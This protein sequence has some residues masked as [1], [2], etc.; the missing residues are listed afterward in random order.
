[1]QRIYD[2]FRFVCKVWLPCS[3]LILLMPFMHKIAYAN[4]T[5]ENDS[6]STDATEND[7][8]TNDNN[9]HY[10]D[11]SVYDRDIYLPISFSSSSQVTNTVTVY[12]RPEDTM[13]INPG[14][15]GPSFMFNPGDDN[16]IDGKVIIEM[17][18]VII[19]DPNDRYD[20]NDSASNNY[21]SIMTS[22]M[23]SQDSLLF[24]VNDNAVF[25]VE[26]N[27]RSGTVVDMDDIINY[28]S[29][30]INFDIRDGGHLILKP[31]PSAAKDGVTE[32]DYSGVNFDGSHITMDVQDE[33][34]VYVRGNMGNSTIVDKVE[35][36]GG[37]VHFLGNMR[38]N[39]LLSPSSTV[40]FDSAA[41][42]P[43][44]EG[45][46]MP[47]E[48]KDG[49]VQ[50]TKGGNF[51]MSFGSKDK[52]L[53]SF[54]TTVSTA[55]ST[56][57]IITIHGD[58]YAETVEL[59]GGD[60]VVRFLGDVNPSE[61]ILIDDEVQEV[62]FQGDSE[63]EHDIYLALDTSDLTGIVPDT[64]H[65]NIY[66]MDD[67]V[68]TAD[69]IGNNSAG[70]NDIYVQDN[71]ELSGVNV[72]SNNF[73]VTGGNITFGDNGTQDGV[74]VNVKE[75]FSN[76]ADI[77]LHGKLF[78][79]SSSFDMA[80]NN[81]I[82]LNVTRVYDGNESAISIDGGSSYSSSNRVLVMAPVYLVDGSTNLLRDTITGS[83]LDNLDI[84]DSKLA[85]YS[86]EVNDN[87][88]MVTIVA[89]PKE[90]E[91]ILDDTGIT[92]DDL[93]ILRQALQAVSADEDSTVISALNRLFSDESNDGMRRVSRQLSLDSDMSHSSMSISPELFADKSMSFIG[94]RLAAVKGKES[95]ISAGYGM[96]D[97]GSG[98]VKAG[99]NYLDKDGDGAN[100]GYTAKGITI[101]M[102]FDRSISQ[103]IKIGAAVG[104]GSSDNK[105]YLRSIH[106][107]ITSYNASVYSMISI[108]KSSYVIA[109][110]GA[111]SNRV[112]SHR[113]I[114]IDDSSSYIANSVVTVK[115]TM[116]R[117]GAGKYF[118]YRG[119][120]FS[121][122]VTL[123]YNILKN[124]GYTE[125]G[126]DSF[127]MVVG[128]G[129]Q[130]IS[131]LRLMNTITKEYLYQSVRKIKRFSFG[132]GFDLKNS[133]DEVRARYAV[134]N[135]DFTL[136]DVSSDKKTALFLGTGVI[137][138]ANWY[139]L[140]WQYDLEYREDLFNH[141]LSASFRY[142]F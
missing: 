71:V 109:M 66:F 64:L 141:S 57:G 26:G 39:L 32:W 79:N 105:S 119:M 110:F 36:T 33:Y 90:D 18:K 81:D 108:N 31:T 89:T 63:I 22:N 29:R 56:N 8:N 125:T 82:T 13:T 115:N 41:S 78:I 21:Q 96:Y 3:T 25:Q 134:M 59:G 77:V 103:A 43:N 53:Q 52:Y 15:E 91:D 116:G 85:T 14:A 127:N 142:R 130:S 75:A 80:A 24:Q 16:T 70:A 107:K 88:T 140:S 120:V 9:A 73:F 97:N 42:F 12:M 11:G 27:I 99:L 40:S 5:T 67:V 4:T 74:S 117:I 111:G 121:P 123:D 2:V 69:R 47:V 133:T 84:I 101:G 1:M 126:A 137:Y 122:V 106:S 51:K 131:R 35:I 44:Y 28:P 58:I 62:R 61:H 38:G 128:S 104:I 20:E 72:I 48:H 30:F 135:D 138:K 92:V 7:T 102:G 139:D 54:N 98:W 46:I 124:P 45:S 118:I 83:T 86:F 129:K 114:D 112:K 100:R 136:S 68:V 17:G 93:T 10:V 60:Q 94:D 19:E 65:T 113:Y 6:G 23:D 76:D 95:G 50:I 34:T 87:N 55:T 49:T 132:I 37:K